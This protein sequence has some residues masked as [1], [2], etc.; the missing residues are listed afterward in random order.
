MKS[1]KNQ[2]CKRVYRRCE[3]Y[4]MYLKGDGPHQTVMI[5]CECIWSSYIFTFHTMIYLYSLVKGS[6]TTHIIFATF[7]TIVQV[8]CDLAITRNTCGSIC[9]LNMLWNKIWLDSFSVFLIY[10]WF[11]SRVEVVF[12]CLTC[13]LI[14]YLVCILFAFILCCFFSLKTSFQA[15]W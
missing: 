9:S 1:R 4:M 6:H 5:V 7:D 13:S 2:S 12:L 14:A 3:S 8:Q 15:S 11:A 10:K